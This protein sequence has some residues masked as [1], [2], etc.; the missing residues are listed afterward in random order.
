MPVI[1]DQSYLKGD[2][3]PVILTSILPSFAQLAEVG[4]KVIT[5]SPALPIIKTEDKATVKAPEDAVKTLSEPAVFIFNPLN[6]A[7]PEDALTVVVPFSVPA[8]EDKLNMILALELVT[9]LPNLS[10]TVTTGC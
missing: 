4:V 5:K 2:T 7:T 6:V 8:P 9:V 1:S 3:P 10:W